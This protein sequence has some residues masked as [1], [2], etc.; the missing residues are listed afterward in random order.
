M[1]TATLALTKLCSTLDLILARPIDLAYL[2]YNGMG[3]L[4]Y[5][6]LRDGI[7]AKAARSEHGLRLRI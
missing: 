2:E 4:I 6:L 1:A 5:Y 7:L 3:N